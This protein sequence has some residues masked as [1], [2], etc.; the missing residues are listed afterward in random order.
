MQLISALFF[1]L[2]VFLIRLLPFRL[3]YVFS[4]F[5]SVFLYR[6]IGYRK[7]VV[8]QNLRN[9]FPEKNSREI[10]LLVKLSYRNL[11]DILLEGLKGFTMSPEKDEDRF[12]LQNPQFLEPYKKRHQNLLMVTAHYGNWEWGSLFLPNQMNFDHL[13]VLYKPLKNKY[14][15]NHLRKHREHFGLV[16]RSIYKTAEAFSELMSKETIFTLVADQSPSNLQRAYWTYFLGQPTAFLHGVEHYAR[17][18][19]L[20]VIYLDIQRKKR[21]FY[22]LTLSSLV[23]EPLKFK[24]GEI[25]SL[26]A[27]KMEE[28]IRR[29]PQDWLWSHKRWKHKP[30]SVS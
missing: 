13:L 8:K 23:E 1:W 25:T 15:D 7:E 9:S 14:L 12:K 3:L 28:I 4:D 26:Y 22:E 10:D 5:L 18:Y 19:N 6:I 30:P 16:I 2:L 20:P 17:L 11:S 27:E 24:E 29:K 21:G